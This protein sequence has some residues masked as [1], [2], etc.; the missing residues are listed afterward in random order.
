MQ[1]TRF[2]AALA[3]GLAALISAKADAT[4]YNLGAD[5]TLFSNPNGVWTYRSESTLLTPDASLGGWT[6]GLLVAFLKTIAPVPPSTDAEIGD[7]LGHATDGFG[8][9]L[10]ILFTAPSSGTANVFGSLWDAQLLPRSTIPTF[11]ELYVN[12]T[13]EA[14][15]NPSIGLESTFRS[16]RD[17]FTLL[18][19]PLLANDTV[20]LKIFGGG[21]WTGMDMTVDFS[22]TP[23][24]GALPLFAS[25]LGALGLL[26]W[27]RKRKQ[28][29]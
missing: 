10:N 8:P 1:V 16:S 27:R 13:L 29:A 6:D 12:N 14:S 20:M 25:G 9:N 2:V 24:P 4:T 18:D 21:D 17:F 11:W 28:A 26:G 22:P 5:W 23:L 19:V 15:G 3:C 7:V